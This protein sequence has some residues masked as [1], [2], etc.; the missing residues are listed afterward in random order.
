MAEPAAGTA[1]GVVRVEKVRGR[2][3]LTRCF[4]KYP[5]KL[6]APSK[7][8]RRT[9]LSLSL[10]AHAAEGIRLVVAREPADRALADR[11]APPPPAPSGSTPSPTAAAS[12]P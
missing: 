10:P 6:I 2:S 4:A 1:T 9:S 5:L 7:V 3:A 12:S 11:W 8:R